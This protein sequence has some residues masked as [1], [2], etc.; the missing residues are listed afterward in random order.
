LIGNCAKELQAVSA[1]EVSKSGGVF[2]SHA[3][4]RLRIW[5][6][7]IKWDFDIQNGAKARNGNIPKWS[8]G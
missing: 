2:E 8:V 5:E 3:V 4:I 6:Q 1:I 7:K